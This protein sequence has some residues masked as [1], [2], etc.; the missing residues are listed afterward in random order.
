MTDAR[1]GVTAE[2]SMWHDFVQPKKTNAWKYAKWLICVLILPLLTVAAIL[3]YAAG[4]PMVRNS[5]TSISWL[6]LFIL[7]NIITFSL[8]KVT[9][10]VIIDYLSLRRRFTVNVFGPHFAL[11]VVQSKGWPALVFWWAV[12]SILLLC[13]FGS[14]EKHWL[15]Y[16]NA[17]K[18]FNASNPDG[19]V[20]EHVLWISIL[21]SAL[22][23]GAAVSLKRLWL[24]LQLGNRAYKAYGEK[25]ATTMDKMLLVSQ[26]AALSRKRP[27]GMYER[28]SSL[29]LNMSFDTDESGKNPSQCGSRSAGEKPSIHGSEFYSSVSN[30]NQQLI[31]QI[32]EQWEEPVRA[33]NNKADTSIAAVLQ[34]RQSLSL[35]DN[36]FL[37]GVAFGPTTN[38][39]CCVKSGQGVY[40]QL[41]DREGSGDVLHFDSIAEIAVKK[42]GTLNR[43][44]LKALVR[45]FRPTRDGE[46]TMI[47]FL[48]SVDSVY[49][50]FRILQASIENAGTFGRAFELMVNWIFYIILWV[51]ILYIVGL[52]PLTM[53]LSVSSFIVGFAFMIGNASSRWLEGLLF[54]L[55]RRPYDIGDRISVSNPEKDTNSNGSMTWFVE[56]LGLYSTTVRLAA[57]N[58]VATYSNGSLSTSRIINANRSPQAVVSILCK[59]SVNVSYGKVQLFKKATEKFVKLRP[60]EWI[61]LLGFR[62]TTCEPELGYIEYTVSLQ[63]RESWQNAGAIATSK[64]DVTSFTL[65]LSKQLGM[66][67]YAPPLPVTLKMAGQGGGDPQNLASGLSPSNDLQ[68]MFLPE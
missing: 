39:E 8:G 31:L 32:L 17:V 51:I 53:F 66:R 36:R 4:N 46:L 13:G 1:Y 38:R 58:E 47:D 59:F 3:F 15:F 63:H 40:K 12:W 20:T 19:G 62:A 57:T 26:V 23:F 30:S 61:A 16:Q 34:F 55:V 22:L 14:F 18:L 67:Y 48:K 35:V 27:L 33:K 56:D 45:I 37:F 6:C 11:L 2:L 43:P 49:K 44:K 65:E 24:G 54:I 5:G 21:I 60:R 29:D 52:D 64:A 50:E 9:E 25:L 10:M 7:R 28:A 68:A 41:F 42:D